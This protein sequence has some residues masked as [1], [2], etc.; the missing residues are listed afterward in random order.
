MATM[1]ALLLA[2]VHGGFGG[3]G[4][5]ATGVSIVDLRQVKIVDNEGKLRRVFPAKG[6]LVFSEEELVA[7]EVQQ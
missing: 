6:D 3:S 4:A 2:M 1:E 7:V 5:T